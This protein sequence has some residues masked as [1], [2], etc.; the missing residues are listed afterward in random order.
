MGVENA[1]YIEELNPD[2]PQGNESISEGDNHIRVIKNALKKSF[3]KVNGEVD[4]TPQDFARVKDYV[5]NP[6]ESPDIPDDLTSPQ[7][8]SCKWNGTA[9]MYSNNVAMVTMAGDQLNNSAGVRITYQNLIP[10]FDYH[11]AVAIQPFATNNRHV[12]ATVS[13]MQANFI[14]FTVIEFDGTNWIQPAGGAISNGF[15]FILV[16]TQ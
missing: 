8:A 15:S 1:S 4:W 9:L 2:Q 7:A 6:P 3:P 5:D 14:E 11:Y 16:D 13:N 10:E 12:V